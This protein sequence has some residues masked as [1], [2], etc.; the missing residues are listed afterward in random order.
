MRV[1]YHTLPEA[2]LRKRL[3]KRGLDQPT[4]ERIVE[5][6][7]ERR[8]ASAE[9]RRAKRF[10]YE[11]WQNIIEPLICEQNTIMASMAYKRKREQL[12]ELAF[13]NDYLYLLRRLLERFRKYQKIKRIPPDEAMKQ[14]KVPVENDG[15]HWSDWI[16]APIKQE[17]ILAYEKATATKRTRKKPIFPRY[18]ISKSEQTKRERLTY[19]I[20]KLMGELE[21]GN[22]RLMPDNPMFKKQH[23]L[24][25]AAHDRVSNMP[26][27][28][29]APR[30]WDALLS[31]PERRLYRTGSSQPV[32]RAMSRLDKNKA[33][34]LRQVGEQAAREAMNTPIPAGIF[35]DLIEGK[36]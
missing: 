22:L 20:E 35:D 27:H 34:Y 29:R 10:I 16:P 15:S 21:R 14:Q 8:T 17:Y 31:A 1:R 23:E 32:P 7:K 12:E 30:K 3:N 28:H 19:T 6:A 5:R 4:I 9:H 2:A 25:C 13:A 26:I 36:I 18:F 33:A 24:L 11:P